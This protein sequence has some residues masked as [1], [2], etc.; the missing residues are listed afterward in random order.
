MIDHPGGHR[1]LTGG[2]QEV[3]VRERGVSME[4]EVGVMQGLKPRNVGTSRSWKNQE[5]DS[6]STLQKEHSSADNLMLAS[7][8]YFGLLSPEL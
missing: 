6:A 8:T 7:E 1:V 5:A 3:S 2:R 4:T